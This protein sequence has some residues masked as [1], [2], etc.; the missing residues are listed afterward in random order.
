[1][2]GSLALCGIAAAQT[3]TDYTIPARRCVPDCSP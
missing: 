1:M 2:K 3:L